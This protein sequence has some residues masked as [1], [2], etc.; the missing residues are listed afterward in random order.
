MSHKQ[1]FI[2]FWTYDANS[3][4]HPVQVDAATYVDAILD[5]FLHRIDSN[6][7]YLVFDC[8]EGN[9]AHW[10]T[11]RSAINRVTP[12]EPHNVKILAD[13]DDRWYDAMDLGHSWFLTHF[14]V[15]CPYAPMLL[16]RKFVEL[17]ERIARDG[18]EYDGVP[19]GTE[20]F[21]A[22]WKITRIVEQEIERELEEKAEREHAQQSERRSHLPPFTDV[23]QHEHVCKISDA[24]VAK[25]ADAP[26]CVLDAIIA[27]NANAQKKCREQLEHAKTDEER[28]MTQEFWDDAV[29]AYLEDNR[30]DE[31][32]AWV[33]GDN[34]ERCGTNHVYYVDA[35]EWRIHQS[36][37]DEK[38]YDHKRVM[39]DAKIIYTG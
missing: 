6:V 30:G 38:P 8:E 31:G 14:G 37:G 4:E 33:I 19:G 27:W 16:Q 25:Y 5:R 36:Y 39:A 34:Y 18:R 2:L 1:S 32:P 21:E 24:L 13:F 10:G 35:D 17:R 26:Q 15:D 22:A 28:W 23:V 3:A 29:C 11:L 7:R 20:L 9:V 12:F